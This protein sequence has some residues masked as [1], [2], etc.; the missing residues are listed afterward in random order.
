MPP[1]PR[2]GMKSD[3]TML[4][5]YVPDLV[6][7]LIRDGPIKLRSIADCVFLIFCVKDMVTQVQSSM[8]HACPPRPETR[9]GSGGAT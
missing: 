5:C 3:P 7:T 2:T 8:V 4:L 1:Q 9:T 6:F